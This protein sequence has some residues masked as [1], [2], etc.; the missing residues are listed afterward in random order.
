MSVQ[1][2]CIADAVALR[3]PGKVSVQVVCP[4]NAP[5]AAVTI[6]HVTMQPG[7]VSARHRHERSEQIWIVEQGE[8]TLLLADGATRRVAAGTVVRTPA[9]EVHG[10]E[11]TGSGVLVYLAVTAPP[12][13]MSPRYAERLGGAQ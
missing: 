12:E 13:D 5:D 4:E 1:I 11:N 10:I 8:G 9:G 2:S 7:A 6:T 3:N